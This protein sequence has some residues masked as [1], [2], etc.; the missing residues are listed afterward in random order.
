MLRG[1]YYQGKYSEAEDMYQQTLE[2]RERVLGKEHPDTLTSMDNLALLL[3]RQGKYG[4]AEEIH[5]RT[6]EI[7]ERP[8]RVLG[9]E[10]PDT[11]ASIYCLAYLLR[12]I[13]QFV[14]S[15][16]KG[17]VRIPEEAWLRSPHY[18]GMFKALLFSA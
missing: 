18:F 16:S 14:C 5:R 10:H 3:I 6:L 9:E 13:R 1:L 7:R 15:L 2:L 4:E 12:A 11:L 8:E 17:F